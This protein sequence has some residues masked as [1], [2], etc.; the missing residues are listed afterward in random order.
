MKAGT[1]GLALTEVWASP[2]QLYDAVSDVRRMGEWSPECQRCEW[3]DVLFQACRA[4]EENETDALPALR[5]F[6]KIEAYGI[7]SRVFQSVLRDHIPAETYS[8]AEKQARAASQRVQKE[9]RKHQVP[10]AKSIVD[11]ATVQGTFD[12]TKT[13]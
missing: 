7:I 2:S 10:T 13:K 5:G 4:V 1:R 12:F 6:D 11:V 9:M 8:R 3:I